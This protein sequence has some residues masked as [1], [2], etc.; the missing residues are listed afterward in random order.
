[1]DIESYRDS[2]WHREDSLRIETAHEAES[3]IKSVG[4]AMGL[5]DA[6]TELPSIYVAV[7]GRRDAYAPRNVQKDPEMSAAWVI[8]DEV[9]MRGKIYYG[10]LHKSRS[11][12]IAPR[13]IPY[14]NAI[15]GIP[16]SKEKDVLSAD[17]RK[18]LKILRKEWDMGTAD[19]RSE[20]GIKDR[21]G[22][23]KA[24]DELQ[25]RMKVIP[26][27]VLYEPKFTYIWTLAEARFPEELSVKIKRE[28]AIK[29]LAKVYLKMCGQTKRG[30]LA[31]ILNISRREA[32]AANHALV[33]EGYAERVSNG[34][35]RVR[36]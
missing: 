36:Q 6:R 10:K 34:V 33:D 15:W 13:L 8:K 7:C 27:E 22:F 5:T 4:F 19:L 18:V 21:A 23:T 30:A 35:Y 28:D 26:Q 3:F 16:K 20:A 2:L 24:V 12:F 31:G 1:M 25:R 32:G 17:A 9:M 11:W 29:E 14:F